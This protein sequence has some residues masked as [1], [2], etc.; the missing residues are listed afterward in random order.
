VVEAFQRMG[1]ASL[2]LRVLEFLRSRLPAH[3]S[4]SYRWGRAMRDADGGSNTVPSASVCS[5]RWCRQAPA[6]AG[7]P[8]GPIYSG[9]KRAL[10]LCEL[11]P[12]EPEPFSP[13]KESGSCFSPS[14]GARYNV[15]SAPSSQAARLSGS[16]LAGSSSSPAQ[17]RWRQA[18]TLQRWPARRFS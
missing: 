12:G 3:S 5:W 18:E 15:F 13:L 9:I 4:E 17:R 16:R 8:A 7:A 6:G 11:E 14:K 10:R 1:T 2:S